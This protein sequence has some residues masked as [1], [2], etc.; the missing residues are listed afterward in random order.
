MAKMPKIGG[1]LYISFPIGTATRVCFNAHR[2]FHPREIL[3]WPGHDRLE[4]IRFDY[5]DDNGEL[6]VNFPLTDRVPVTTFGCGIYTFR[7]HT[8]FTS[9]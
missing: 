4:L 8:K 1:T 7:K 9:D 6:H 3:D 5:V 2:V